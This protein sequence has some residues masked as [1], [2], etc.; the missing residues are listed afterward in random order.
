MNRPL[1][2][3]HDALNGFGSPFVDIN[4][5]TAQRNF[6]YAVNNNNDMSFSPSDYDLYKVGEFD[7]EKGV[8]LPCSI[9][10]LVVKGVS[11]FNAKE[12]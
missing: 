6:A 2:A 3:I 12:T 4:D 10:V 5:A 11:V 9:P 7:H 8:L 1:Y